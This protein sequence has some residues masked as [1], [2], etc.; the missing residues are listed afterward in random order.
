MS[1]I[2]AA[3][4]VLYNLP[5]IRILDGDGS[6]LVYGRSG[7]EHKGTRQMGTLKVHSS[8]FRALL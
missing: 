3:L 8:H 6:K 5:V 7:A 4:N 1:H 2:F